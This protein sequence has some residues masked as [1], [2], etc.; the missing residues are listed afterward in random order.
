MA[1][2]FNQVHSTK[3]QRLMTRKRDVAGNEYIYLTGV[4]STAAGSW[5]VFDELGITALID[6]DTAA[7][8]S[9]GGF[10]AVAQAATVASTY[11]WYMIAGSCS[12]AAATVA[13]NGE[14]FPTSTA[15]TADDTGTG[16]LQI[17]G[18]K[19]RSADSSGF[20]TVQ[21]LYPLIGVDVA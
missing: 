12:A 13:D 6:T 20:A 8:T 18:A 11:G 2:P 21:L 5:V 4:A 7:T 19:W 10:V 3:K 1:A 14:V 15:G 16:G 9:A 17:V